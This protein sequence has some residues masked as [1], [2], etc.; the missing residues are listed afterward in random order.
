MKK[1]FLL[2]FTLFSVYANAQDTGSI[3]GKLT[4]KE[5]D[6]EP[7][8]FANIL[9]KGTS[10]GTTT[11]DAGLYMLDN[12]KPGDYVIEYSFVG[13]ETQTIEATVEAGKVTEINVPMGANAASLEEV[14]I[15]TTTKR[16][17]EVAVLLEQKKAVEI[18]QIIGA[19]ELSRKGVSDA[20]GAVAKISGVSKQ[21]GS[22][23]VYVRGLGDRYLNTT[24]NGLS[25]PSNNVNKKNID[26]NLF[27][28]D[29]IQ[30][31]SISKAYAAQFYGDFSAGNVDVT[32]KRT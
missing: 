28:S 11:D 21:E 6:N 3:A 16:E 23:N 24:M 2:L 18:K 22:S 19:D 10:K 27:S 17:S 12:L 30:N 8:P 31:V 15:Q 4:D 32:S 20:A 1:I 7:L 5:F 9:I 13:Y 14:V 29:V 26:L 25:L